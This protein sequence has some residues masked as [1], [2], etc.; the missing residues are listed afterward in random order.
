MVFCVSAAVPAPQQLGRRVGEIVKEEMGKS[1]KG[2]S[3]W[4]ICSAPKKE[5]DV[6]LTKKKE[7]EVNRTGESV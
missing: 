1:L 2:R 4:E 7:T 6:S 3:L 5:N